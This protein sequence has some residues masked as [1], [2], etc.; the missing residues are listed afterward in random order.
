MD[1]DGSMFLTG[2]GRDQADGD[3]W[4]LL[5][6]ASSIN[7]TRRLD[8]VAESEWFHILAQI[9]SSLLLFILIFGMSATV[10]VQHLREQVHNKFA[11]L[12]GVATQFIIMP[13]LGFVSVILL[14]D[15]GLTEPMAISLLIVT[16]SPGGSYSNWWCSMFNADLALSVTM[17]A[18]ST[19][20]STIM[21]PANLL[22]YVNAAF[23]FGSEGEGGGSVL[24]KID[25]ASLFVS[26]A[27]VILAI[28]LGLCASFKISSHR[29]NRF[30]NRMGSLSGILLIIFSVVVTSISGKNEAQI[31]GQPWSFYVGVTAPCLVGL[32]IATCFGAIARL[33]HPEVITVGVECCYQNVGIAT[34]AAVAMFD[35]PVDKA[36]A[37]CVPLFYGLMEAIV[38]G[39]YCIIAWKLGWTKAPRDEKFCVMIVTTYE[40]D[41][42][43]ER[44]EFVGGQM[45]E[46]RQQEHASSV[47]I[48]ESVASPDTWSNTSL[49][50]HEPSWRRPWS[51]FFR[52]RKRK[53]SEETHDPAAPSPRRDSLSQI[54]DGL[55]SI[56]QMD[57]I[58]DLVSFSDQKYSRCRINSEDSVAG[59]TITTTISESASDGSPNS[60]ENSRTKQ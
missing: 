26:L 27:I 31:W 47:V 5:E 23:G 46:E 50:E 43:T 51:I 8:T 3:P 32:F 56:S 24:E 37:L 2:T 13:L 18:I 12:I 59:T 40:V 17:T 54:S 28:A 33:K 9:I 29:F 36:Q 55:E 49:P 20:I 34:S 52:K 16:A 58:S 25:W 4:R 14:K 42:D 45:D 11:I 15:H 21:L 1:S 53:I 19:M 60:L 48:T 6:S 38:L 57:S 35:D 30:A 39:I 41:D 22:L 7:S 10:D 44:D